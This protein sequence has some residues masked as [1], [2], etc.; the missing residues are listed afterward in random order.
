MKIRI[1]DPLPVPHPSVWAR[2]ANESEL[3]NLFWHCR[4]AT[5]LHD[6]LPP[7]TARN[8]T[9]VE[10]VRMATYCHVGANGVQYA[11]QDAIDAAGPAPNRKWT[12]K[13]LTKEHVVPVA[14]IAGFVREALD[15]PPLIEEGVLSGLGGA[16]YPRA[17]AALF[18]E[19]ARAWQMACVV[20]EWALMA[21]IT[22]VENDRF[23]DKTRHGGKTIRTCM[24]LGWTRDQCRF[25]R[26]TDC[27]IQL[28]PLT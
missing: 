10:A 12:G 13:G 2:A 7:S 27:N 20:R 16:N 21:W 26:Y 14:V 4:I 17:V 3:T 24:P 23:S 28:L 6:E 22:G 9:F 18:R 5:K 25:K 8:A 1:D 11:S 15:Q 19:H